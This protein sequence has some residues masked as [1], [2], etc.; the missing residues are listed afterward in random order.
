MGLLDRVTAD[1]AE[2]PGEL[3]GRRL[4]AELLGSDPLRG[5]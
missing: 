5:P 2:I 4:P 3:L 1:L